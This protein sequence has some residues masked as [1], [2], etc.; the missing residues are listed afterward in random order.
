MALR[1][2]LPVLF[3]TFFATAGGYLLRDNTSN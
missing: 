3:S 1:L 2:K